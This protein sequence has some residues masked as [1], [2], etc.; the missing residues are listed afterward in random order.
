MTVRA[1]GPVG[2][3]IW[4]TVIALDLTTISIGFSRTVSIGLTFTNSCSFSDVTVCSLI[5]ALVISDN[6]VAWSCEGSGVWDDFGVGKGG[7]GSAD[8]ERRLFLGAA[9]LLRF[10]GEVL[11]EERGTGGMLSSGS[12]ICD[13]SMLSPVRFL[14]FLAAVRGVGGTSA[15]FLLV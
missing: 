14:R 11:I 6:G 4:G 3:S 12:K 7:G 1:F 2:S 5:V 15:V 10:R 13:G 9:V 8:T